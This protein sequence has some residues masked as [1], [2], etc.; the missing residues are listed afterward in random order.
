MVERS[1]IPP[2]RACDHDKFAALHT[3]CQQTHT[4]ERRSETM[5]LK[6]AVSNYAQGQGPR[7]YLAK[8]DGKRTDLALTGVGKLVRASLEWYCRKSSSRVVT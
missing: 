7:T 8:V 3:T 5:M 2:G 6:C 1:L 4:T